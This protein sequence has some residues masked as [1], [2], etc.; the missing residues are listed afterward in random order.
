MVPVETNWPTLR[1]STW[2]MM[3]SAGA[4]TVVLARLS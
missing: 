4:A 1:L 2:L 3:P